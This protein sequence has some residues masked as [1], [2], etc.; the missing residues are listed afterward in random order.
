VLRTSGSDGAVLATVGPAPAVV[1][2]TPGAEPVAEGGYAAALL[3]D[4]WAMLGRP[5]LRAAEEALRRWLGAAALVRPASDGGVVVVVAGAATPAVQALVRW[6]PA[7]FAERELAERAELRFPPAAAVASLTGSAGAVREFVATAELSPAADLLGPVPVRSRT[8][9]DEAQ[10]RLV[11]RV[12][13]GEA[14]DLAAALHA[15]AGVR[16]A[17]KDA[18]PVRVQIDPLEMG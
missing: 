16:S 12:A 3:L 17:H 14:R 1:V 15:A 11:V 13:R 18:G 5:D 4:G 10:E 6:D 9:G 7:T 8:R 2:A